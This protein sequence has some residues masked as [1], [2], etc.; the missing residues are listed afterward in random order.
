MLKNTT[1]PLKEEPFGTYFEE[2]LQ[3]KLKSVIREMM[4]ENHG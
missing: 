2:K 3:K 4:R 1:Q